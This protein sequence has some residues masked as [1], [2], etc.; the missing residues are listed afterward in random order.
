MPGAGA[1]DVVALSSFFSP[2]T[3]RGAAAGVWFASLDNENSGGAGACAGTDV[4]AWF[5]PGALP[6]V[7]AFCALELDSPD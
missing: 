4:V 1:D 7:K 5:P 3:N 2:K 6:K